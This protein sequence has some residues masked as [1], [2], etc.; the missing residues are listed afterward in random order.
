MLFHNV[1]SFAEVLVQYCLLDCVLFQS[2][3]G[4]GRGGGIGSNGRYSVFVDSFKPCG[5]NFHIQYH[6]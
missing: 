2:Y 4:M 6:M 1:V 3:D 5:R